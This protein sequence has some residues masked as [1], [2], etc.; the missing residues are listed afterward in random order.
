MSSYDDQIEKV[1]Y[2][3]DRIASSLVRSGI[4]PDNA[5]IN[6]RL[7]S[8]DTKLALFQYTNVQE[9]A[10]FDTEKANTDFLLIYHDLL[11]LYQ[12]VYDYHFKKYE[13]LRAYVDTHLTELETLASKYE[14]KTNFETANTNLGDTVFFQ[15]SGFD[16]DIDNSVA[17]IDLGTVS[18][19]KGS[20]AAFFIEGN[21]FKNDN[22]KFYLGN[23]L[24]C[25][26]YTIR[27]NT[28]TIPGEAAFNTYACTFTDD[29]TKNSMFVLNGTAFTP[30]QKDRYIIY[31]GENKV[32]VTSGSTSTYQDKA[33]NTSLTEYNSGRVT[34]YVLN[35]TYITF[36]MSKA[37][38]SRN[39]SGYN[40]DSPATHQKITFEYEG[41][42]TFN[43]MTDG[44]VYAEK[45]TGI[46]KDNELYYP[47][48]STF[49][50]YL[51]E[52]YTGEDT[53]DYNLKAV[54]TDCNSEHIPY[55][56]MITVKEIDTVSEVA[57]Q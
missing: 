12:L 46:I 47:T 7:E 49:T 18:F 25:D 42:F 45:A 22:V 10:K 56:S 13:A 17:T 30:N 33:A 3:R 57:G 15:T 31:T 14:F 44:D 19:N 27:N 48:A 54:I 36:D 43:F 55:I 52:E 37:P 23:D 28:V 4:Y 11:I 35:A 34:F 9:S 39:F 51:I 1:K 2:L 38:L 24:M 5:T 40:I 32:K 8:V 16:M 29:I 50:E 41:P 20:K 26:P 53:V 6:K 21:Y